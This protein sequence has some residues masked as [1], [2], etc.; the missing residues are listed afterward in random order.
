MIVG[1]NLSND[2][3]EAVS[4]KC[5][6]NGQSVPFVLLRQ[7]GFIGSLRIDLNEL[8]A[9]EKKHYMKVINDLRLNNPFQELIDFSFSKQFDLPS[10]ESHV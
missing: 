6:E 3:A 8:C 1:S 5:R 7:Y 2:Q 9:I 10:L 4:N